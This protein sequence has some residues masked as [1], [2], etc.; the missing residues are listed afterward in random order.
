MFLLVLTCN[1]LNTLALPTLIFF[2]QALLHQHHFSSLFT[3]FSLLI[4]V[5]GD[6]IKLSCHYQLWSIN[7]KEEKEETPTQGSPSQQTFTDKE[8][9]HISDTSAAPS[10]CSR[11]EDLSLQEGTHGCQS[12]VSM[13]PPRAA[14]RQSL[15]VKDGGNCCFQGI[16]LKRWVVLGGAF[17]NPPGADGG[18]GGACAPLP[19]CGVNSA[20]VVDVFLAL[21]LLCLLVFWPWCCSWIDI[22]CCHWNLMLI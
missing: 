7:L 4:L 10:V 12:W 20:V 3:E 1:F 13:D 17:R 19:E 6:E 11:P 18:N 15:V 21:V 14:F 9:T 22:Y 5:A 16:F 2:R 8:N